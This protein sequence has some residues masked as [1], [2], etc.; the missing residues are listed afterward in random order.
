MEEQIIRTFR[1]TES[2]SHGVL[3]SPGESHIH[4]VIY[5]IH[6]K[7]KLVS[8]LCDACEELLAGIGKTE[9]MILGYERVVEVVDIWVLLRWGIKVFERLEGQ[10]IF[11]D[12]SMGNVGNCKVV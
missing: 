8:G 3:E 10:V 11:G 12:R 5:P 6:T 1:L 7:D 4:M 2:E 9:G